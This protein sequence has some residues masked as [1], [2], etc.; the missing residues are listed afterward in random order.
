M[1]SA[2]PASSLK[3]EQNGRYGDTK[4]RT[5]APQTPKRLARSY[6]CRGWSSS[7]SFRLSG[8]PGWAPRLPCSQT[9]SSN[10]RAAR[11]GAL[12][13]GRKAGGNDRG[14]DRRRWERLEAEQWPGLAHLG[15]TFGV[16]QDGH[17]V[18][19]GNRMTHNSWTKHSGQV[20]HIHPCLCAVSNPAG[21]LNM[22]F[23]SPHVPYYCT[24]VRLLTSVGE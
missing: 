10:R 17:W 22:S 4:P 15:L 24:S 13:P 14:Y 2:V 5:N 3:A 9:G 19:V 23:L 7:S 20:G 8:D 6:F 1:W 16:L 21:F 12:R 11:A 18:R